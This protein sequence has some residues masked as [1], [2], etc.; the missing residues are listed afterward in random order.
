MTVVRRI[1][2]LFVGSMAV[3]ALS[4][5]DRGGPPANPPPPGPASPAAA[6]AKPATPPADTLGYVRGEPPPAAAPALPAGHPPIDSG[7][8]R[9]A[10]ALPPASPGEMD[11]QFTA[12]ESWVSQPPAN[13]MR[14][15]QFALPRVEGDPEDGLLTVSRVG[16]PVE[17]N[18]SRWRGMFKSADG[19][20]IDDAAIQRETFDANGLQV[21]IVDMSG[22]YADAMTRGD[23]APTTVDFRLLGGVVEHPAGNWYFK[24]TGPA[25]TMQQHR[26]AFMEFMKS[27]R[28]K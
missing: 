23:G 11:V 28:P 16:G 20:P 9:P 12:P 1:A 17:M 22:R 24:A 10:A 13:P 15:A 2:F 4:G 14:A 3:T 6:A 25:P 19:Q 26:D 18:L 8:R 27:M 5:C 7:E 21:T